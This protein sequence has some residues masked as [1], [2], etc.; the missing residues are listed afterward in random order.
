M[1]AREQYFDFS[2]QLEKKESG[3]DQEGNSQV[4]TDVEQ[5]N[6]DDL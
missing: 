5:V 2:L 3:K 6:I 1:A 4:P